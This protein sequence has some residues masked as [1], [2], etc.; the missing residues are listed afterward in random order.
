[1]TTLLTDRR[2]RGRGVGQRFRWL[3]TP[4]ALALVAAG[5]GALSAAFVASLAFGAPPAESAPSSAAPKRDR[6]GPPAA[7]AARDVDALARALA[8]PH[9]PYAESLGAHRIEDRA[10]LRLRS[11]DAEI[12]SLAVERDIA[13]AKGQRFR[14][15][16]ENSAGYAR[17]IVVADGALYTRSGYG[18]FH[19]RPPES[20]GEAREL[21]EELTSSPQ[22]YA[23]ALLPG[24]AIAGT[25]DVSRGDREGLA[26]AL[27]AGAPGAES[28]VGLP[29]QRAEV[30]DVSGELVLDVQTGAL[31]SADVSGSLRLVRASRQ[32]V[33]DVAFSRE[34]ESA[35][36]A[37]TIDA[38][39][40]DEVVTTLDRPR[41]RV[42]PGG[43]RDRGGQTGAE[44]WDEP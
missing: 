16:S 27:E 34:L 42:R 37:H 23:G 12:E 24:A 13:F 5:S 41:S 20:E 18:P 14:A 35:A 10:E 25:R 6:S 26:I 8:R 44:P 31:L 22:A 11:G 21:A 17:E 28:D 36:D 19:M 33:L 9:P 1:M 43:R 15:H 7:R 30:E 32:I 3:W 2:D 39:E 29:D 4:G 38:P 40:G